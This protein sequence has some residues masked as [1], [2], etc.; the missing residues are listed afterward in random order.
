MLGAIREKTQGIFAVIIVGLLTIPFAL[1]GIQSYFEAKS[2]LPVA[3]VNGNE[4]GQDLYQDTLR[5]QASR[6]RASQVDAR[7]L[8]SAF[9]KQ[10]VL[11]SLVDEMLFDEQAKDAG[12]RVGNKQ[13]NQLLRNRPEFQVDGKFDAD[14]YQA[15]LRNNGLNP[16]EFERQQRYIKLQDQVLT[17]FKES[18]IVTDDEVDEVLRLRGQMRQAAYVTI[19]PGNFAHK[20]S[21]SEDEI[22]D[23]YEANKLRYQIPDKVRLEYIQLS[24]AAIVQGQKASDEEIRQRYQSQSGQYTTPAKRYTSH[25]LLELPSDAPADEEKKVLDKIK[26]IRQQAAGGGD[27]AELAKKYSQDPIT[28]KRGGN[29][30]EFRPGVLPG[31]D[32][33]LAVSRLKQ[34]EVSQPVRSKYGYHLIRLDRLVPARVKPLSEVRKEIAETIKRERSERLFSELRERLTEIVYEKSGSLKPA[35]EELN[36]KIQKTDWLTRQGGK[37]IGANPGAMQAAFSLEVRQEKLNSEPIETERNVLTVLRILEDKPASTRPLAEV[38]LRIGFELRQRKMQEMA[39]TAGEDMIKQAQAGK[40][41]SGLVGTIPGASYTAPRWLKRQDPRQP[42]ASGVDPAITAKVFATAKPQSGKSVH[43]GVSLA[44]GKGYV[45]F[46][47]IQVK[48]G[49]PKAASKEDREKA[50][51]LL[52]QRHGTGYYTDYLESVRKR[53]DIKT[54]PDRI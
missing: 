9:F 33:E 53:A 50:R 32:I 30:G 18:A 52:T 11:Q 47:L 6:M 14:R 1:W 46:E 37:G 48:P 22:K 41:L 44:G 23:Y 3:V 13:L 24:L 7:F 40:S 20:V 2:D 45:V 5:R 8:E 15:L 26:G 21:V 29:L 4:I 16:V 49:D 12:Y 42:A 25:I 54:F 38:R 31:R 27:F 43:D 39:K 35:A 19:R 10:R 28:G 17:G 36:L 34:G 51:T